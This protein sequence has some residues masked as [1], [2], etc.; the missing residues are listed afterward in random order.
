MLDGIGRNTAVE[1][2]KGGLAEKQYHSGARVGAS[3]TPGV[4]VDE[5]PALFLECRIEPA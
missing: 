5:A 1:L 4:E 2:V 3:S